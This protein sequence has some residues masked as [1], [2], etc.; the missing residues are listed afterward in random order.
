MSEENEPLTAPG[1][2][3]EAKGDGLSAA[4]RLSPA[5]ASSL[6][7]DNSALKAEH[8]FSE[9][10][11]ARLAAEI[12]SLK[13]EIAEFRRKTW[14]PPGHFYSPLTSAEEIRL[15]DHEIWK[16]PF[17]DRTLGGIG[18]NEEAQWRLF[19]EFVGYYQE[20][21]WAT[22]KQAHRR[23]F[24]ENENFSYSDALFLYYMLRHLRPHTLI[25][26]GSGYSSCAILDTNELFLDHSMSCIFI[27]PHTDLLFSLITEDDKARI[28]VIPSRVQ[29]ASIEVF[30]ALDRG[31][32]LFIDSTHVS[33]TAS[34][35]NHIFFEVL[36]SL[37][38]GVFIHLHDIYYPFVYPKDWEYEGRSWNETYLLRAFLQYNSGFSI[39]LYNSFLQYFH[40]DEFKE[41]MPLSMKRT[42][43][44]IWLKKL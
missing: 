19:D 3:L 26:V 31:D 13:A 16:R 8:R 11:R 2:P 33:K 10:E 30:A 36:P 1:K 6:E 32:V 38:S 28:E 44:S 15:K 34:D 39:Y 17:P 22:Q 12:G 40:D 41:Q 29:D 7:S 18:L 9:I 5:E 23:Y 24:F 27:E 20:Q 43:G 4:Q 42:G 35:V 21:P 37:K 14:M 25:E